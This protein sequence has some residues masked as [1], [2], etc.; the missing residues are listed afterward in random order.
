M[1][2]EGY[3]VKSEMLSRVREARS[4]GAHTQL[5]RPRRKA[6]SAPTRSDRKYNSRAL[7][8]PTNWVRK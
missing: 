3:P 7:A 1:I 5:V 6:S 8:E 2:R 4:S